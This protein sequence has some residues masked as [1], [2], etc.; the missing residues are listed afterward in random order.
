VYAPGDIYARG[1]HERKLCEKAA[2]VDWL[3]LSVTGLTTVGAVWLNGET[4]FAPSVPVRFAGPAA[5]GLS[6]GWLVGSLPLALP[7]CS[8]TGMRFGGREG[9]VRSSFFLGASLALAGAALASVTMAVATGQQPQEWG[10]IE[11][12]G[13]VAT[14]AAVAFGGALMP[15]LLPPKPWRAAQELR[16]LRFES[17]NNSA[18]IG[19]TTSF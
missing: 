7:Q 3:Y 16:K 1:E 12:A 14:T 2:K 19:Y 6:V 18:L 9:D 5:I 11:R 8:E 17:G 10:T 15:Y 4:K 13:R